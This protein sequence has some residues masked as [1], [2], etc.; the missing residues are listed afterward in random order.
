MD[1]F[2]K[3]S[4]F[5]TG[6]YTI[7]PVSHGKLKT[8]KNAMP[9]AV[10]LSDLIRVKEQQI[11]IERSVMMMQFKIFFCL[12]DIIACCCKQRRALGR[13]IS[14]FLAPY[15]K[16]NTYNSQYSLLDKV[17]CQSMSDFQISNSFEKLRSFCIE[18]IL[19]IFL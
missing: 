12:H 15:W 16:E 17:S 18:V 2:P 8:G 9:S 7:F 4:R 11:K 14:N 19:T 1:D 6:N 13:P 10:L 3:F 5:L